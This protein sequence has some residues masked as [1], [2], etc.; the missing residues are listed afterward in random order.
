MKL[1][2]WRDVSAG[3][4]SKP[5][6]AERIEQYKQ[7]A[8]AEMAL[9]ELRRARQLTQAQLARALGV[10][11]SGV[12]R[13]E[14]EADLYLSTLRSYVE[15]MGGR[16]ELRAVFEDATIP[17]ADLAEPLAPEELTAHRTVVVPEPAVAGTGTVGPAPG[18][19]VMHARVATA[20]ATAL[21]A[22]LTGG[23]HEE[24]LDVRARMHEL[25]ARVAYLERATRGT[26]AAAPEEGV[27]AGAAGVERSGASTVTRDQ[28]EGTG[29]RGGRVGDADDE[30]TAGSGRA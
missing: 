12:S 1:H 24:T 5:G 6:A 13:I 27:R 19:A 18:D 14:N 10:S 4:R 28:V 11:Q 16:L 9:Y 2:K 22:A 26:P 7:E 17:I 23:D 3:L 20:T 8:R 25:Q 15:A 21:P 30:G 29:A